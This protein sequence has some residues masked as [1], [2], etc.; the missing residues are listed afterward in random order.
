MFI[1]R[2]RGRIGSVKKGNWRDYVLKRMGR[3]VLYIMEKDILVE[4]RMGLVFGER[5]YLIKI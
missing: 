2:V 5:E 4:F 1:F 3:G